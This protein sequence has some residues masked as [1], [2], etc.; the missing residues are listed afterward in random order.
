MALGLAEIILLGLLADYLTR[1][2]R[3]PGLVGLLLL[4][5]LLG[6]YALALVNAETAAVAADWRMIAL[7]VILLRAGLEM[8]KQALAKVGTRAVLMAFVPC[9]FETAF[10]TLAGPRLLGISILES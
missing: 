10:V 5:V 4:G 2:L 7:V 9:L 1:K 3:L 6:P 8:S